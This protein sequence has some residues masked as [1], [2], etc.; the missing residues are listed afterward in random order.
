L[1]KITQQVQQRPA[2]KKTVRRVFSH[3]EDLVAHYG[4]MAPGRNAILASGHVPVTYGK[5][6]VRVKDVVSGLRSLGID[7]GD[8]V[9]VVLPNG[10]EAAVTV[11]A[12]ATAAVCVPLNPGFTADESYRYFGDLQLAA[13]LT[14]ADMDSACR[15]VAHSLGIPVIDLSPRPSE[16]PGAFTLVG[17]GTHGGTGGGRVP[18][19]NDH[20][21]ILFTSGTTSRPKMVPLT[22]ASVC[23]SAYNAAAVLQLDPR[24]RLLNVLPLFHA[25]GLISG[26]LTALA[27]GSSVVCT[28][29]FDPAAFF[30]WLTEFRPTWY[31]AV[32]AIHRAL[33]SAADRYR[34]SVRRCSLRV[35]RSASATLPSDVLHELES[36]FGVPV[37]ETYGMTEAAS[38]IAANP[39]GRRKPGSVGQPAGAQIA[40]MDHEGRRLAADERGEIAL[41]GPTITM[42]YDNDIAATQSA[43]RD[44]WFLTGDLG[45]L[46]QDGY[47]FIVGRIK[48]VIKR[49]GQQVAPAEVEEALLRHPDVV[50]AAAFSIPHERL[51][52]DVSAAVVLRP[53]AKISV[54]KLRNFARERLARFKVPGLIR[55]VPAIPKTAGGKI[56]RGELAAALSMTSS[57]ARVEPGNK[58]VP[59]HSE[60][61]CQLAKIWADLLEL[62]QIGID[63]DIFA[64]GADSITVTQMLSRLRTRFGVDLSFEDIFDAPTVETLAARLESWDRNSA[65]ASLNLHD[66]PIEIA[67]V[68]RDAPHPVSILQ[69]HLLRIERQLPG[70]PRFNLPFAYRLQGPLNVAAL[71]RSL[72][73][74]MRRHESLRTAFDWV[75]GLPVA[76]IASAADVGSSVAVEDLA[77]RLLAGDA[78][79]KALLLKKAELEAELAALMPFDLNQAPLFRMRLFRLGTDDH[80]LLLILHHIII[81]GWSMG[82][83]IEEV[84]Q[85]YA[86]FAAGRQP[87]LPEPALQ[88]SDFARWQRRWCASSTADRQFA[89]WKARLR[90]VSPVFPANGQL[91]GPLLAERNTREPFHVSNDLVARL[92]ALSHSRG[93]TLFMTLLAGLKILLLARSGR[94]DICVA[95]A[96]ANRSQPGTERVI[97]PLENTILIRTRIDADL[98]FQEAL[99]R[100]RN[101]VLQ[102]YAGQE[103]PFEILAPRLAQED[104]LDP[105]SLIQV[106]FL[107]QNAFRPLKLPEVAVRPLAYPEGQ[108]VM[109]IDRTCFTMIVQG[110]PSGIAGAC[111]CKHDFFEPNAPQNWIADY[112]TILDKAAANPE[113]SLGRLADG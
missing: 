67:R 13:L 22:H 1:S 104:G 99:G 89:C 41:R 9:A 32:P 28:P 19:A 113:M 40:I 21:F 103:L 20:A 8:R 55:I 66:P 49:G 35:I 11:I 69:E 93:A 73:E 47:L 6:P 94:S 80:L 4:R 83:L 102:A 54:R 58:L 15:N 10:P 52:E 12:V 38:Q 57:S 45:Y 26:L 7:R 110:T 91:G 77:A 71:E 18:T 87:Q 23:L 90:E 60:L 56:K 46:D 31:T 81:D 95:T 86:A 2:G 34:D 14:L 44:G 36:L 39:L 62:N 106:F 25:H 76:R 33:L 79:A 37:I 100:V 105:A 70:L 63:D 101:S 3:L 59:P 65:A 85:L 27:A 24:D 111:S 29:A 84:S 51:G 74:V 48:D 5:L 16:G 50:E 82:G 107:L 64:L 17:S 109:P 98:S 92:S 72:T 61:Q 78:R 30:G 75:D 88:F 68:E 53:D 43:F 112:K 96:M 108:P 42:G 97:G